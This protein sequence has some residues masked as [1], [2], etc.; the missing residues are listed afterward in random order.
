MS[1]THTH[2][3]GEGWARVDECGAGG[4]V[5][6]G[7]GVGVLSASVRRAL[8]DDIGAAVG[9]RLDGL[10]GI[11]YRTCTH[12]HIDGWIWMDGWMGGADVCV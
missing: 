7:V 6:V 11:G 8:F 1:A 9:E 3:H 4:G 12:R 2:A 5:G 10:D